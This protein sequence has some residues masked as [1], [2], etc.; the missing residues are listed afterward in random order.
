MLTIWM[1]TNSKVELDFLLGHVMMKKLWLQGK[2]C[3]VGGTRK[4]A[5]WLINLYIIYNNLNLYDF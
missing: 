4:Y 3:I 5:Q 1:I 2:Y